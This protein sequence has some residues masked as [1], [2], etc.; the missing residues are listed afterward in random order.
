MTTDQNER[1]RRQAGGK[2]NKL[3]AIVTLFPIT[4]ESSLLKAN[5]LPAC[6]YSVNR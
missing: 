6:D 4:A 1:K 2:E 5:C 3:S